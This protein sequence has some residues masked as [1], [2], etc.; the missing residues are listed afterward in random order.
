MLNI[1]K[2]GKDMHIKAKKD[3]LLSIFF[4]VQKAVP[5]KTPMQILKGFFMEA[6]QNEFIIIANNLELSIKAN[7][8]DLE[9]FNTGSVVI[10]EKIVDILRQL[11]DEDV[12]LK[13]DTESFKVE[14][15]SGKVNFSLYGIDPEEFPSFSEKEQWSSWSCLQFKA[16]DFIHILKGVIFAVSQDEGKPAFKGVLLE[17]A[18]DEK[19]L[20]SLATDTYRLALYE[21]N[22]IME[23]ET[24]PF[25]LLVPGKLLNEII[26]IIEDPDE[27][28]QCYFKDN[29]LV[30]L[31]KNFI[32]SSRLLDDKYPELKTVF[33]PSF[34]TSILVKKEMLARMIQRATLLSSGYNQMISLRI[35]DKYLQVRAASDL[36]KM[37]EE[38]LLE[39]KEGE[40]LEEIFLNARFFLDPLRILD[41]DLVRIEFNGTLGPCVFIQ[42]KNEENI[43]Y[44]YRYL[45]LPIKTEKNVF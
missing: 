19:K 35:E 37:D 33:P 41:D 42:D 14:I 7:I 40:N 6:K 27:E 43:S 18:G 3:S 12:E 1:F 38:L 23:N 24:S 5:S 17:L 36:G 28:I 30:V 34:S 15:I 32:F 21:K 31:Y 45:V 10:Q 13:M 9:I 29:E 44:L 20:Y 26:K 8:N 2:G 16:K 11:P 39:E 25:R 22:Y 4:V